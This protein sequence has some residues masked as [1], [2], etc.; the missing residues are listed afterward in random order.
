MVKHDWYIE[1]VRTCTTCEGTGKNHRPALSG[2][3]QT[4]YLQ[5]PPPVECPKCEGKTVE[6]KRYT[7]PELAAELKSLA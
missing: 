7:L 3:G 1:A 2:P 4:E 5:G 6:Q